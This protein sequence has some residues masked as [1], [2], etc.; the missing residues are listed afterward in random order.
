MS[1]PELQTERVAYAH[2]GVELEGF[3][4]RARGLET[5]RPGVLVAH[6]WMGLVPFVEERA[7]ELARLGYIAF[8]L[9]LYGKDRRPRDK[10][11]AGDWMKRFRDDPAL[12]RARARA[13]LDVLAGI[14]GVD[15]A[16]LAAIGYCFGGGV[17]I[18]LARSGADVRGVVSFH[19]LLDT[20]EPAL[21]GQ[22]RAKVLALHGVQDPLVKDEHVT[23]FVREM[24]AAD[25]DWQLVTYGHA[26]HG[27]TNPALGGDPTSGLFYNAAAD[28][29]SWQA[30][31]SFLDELFG[32]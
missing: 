28:H 18:E 14:E 24:Q 9:D 23:A 30:M 22:V 26:G 7:Q 17:V 1:E 32:R 4:A 16:R 21:P 15:R 10:D 8:A 20:P 29:R 31:R 12:L 11:E 5:P 2:G 25:V 19:G 27:F 3:L 6:M 13:G